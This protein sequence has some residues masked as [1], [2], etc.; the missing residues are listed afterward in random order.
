MYFIDLLLRFFRW[1]KFRGYNK[2]ISSLLID[3]YKIDDFLLNPNSDI[4]ITQVKH[5][6]L[7]GFNLKPFTSM[8]L[9]EGENLF[10]FDCAVPCHY[11]YWVINQIYTCKNIYKDMFI[12]NEFKLGITEDFGL[13]VGGKNFDKVIYVM[14]KL[15]DST[16]KI[17]RKKPKNMSIEE[18][19]KVINTIKLY[20]EFYIGNNYSFCLDFIINGNDNYRDKKEDLIL[21]YK[22]LI[23]YYAILIKGL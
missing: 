11:M 6:G 20:L 14:N 3:N 18:W 16:N 2:K 4:F 5:I 13:W 21:G 12:Y 19:D 7:E 9:R 1:I 22:Y 15:R 8:D 10:L 23:E 17:C